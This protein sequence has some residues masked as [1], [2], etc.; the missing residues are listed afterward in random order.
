MKTINEVI[1]SRRFI[2]KNKSPDGYDGVIHI[3]GWEGTVVVS[4]GCGWDHVSVS[5]R[6]NSYTPT[7]DDMCAIKDIFFKDEE[8]VI[9]IHPPKSE[10]VNFKTNCLHLWRTNDREMDLPPAFMVGPRGGQSIEDAMREAKEYRESH[11]YEW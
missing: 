1:A 7:W 6:K 5:P 10:Y 8:A 2:L 11:G 3:R 9:Q 4:W